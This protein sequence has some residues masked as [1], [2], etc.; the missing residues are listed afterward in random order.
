MTAF[1]FETPTIVV[2]K[3]QKVVVNCF[4]CGCTIEPR[5]LASSFVVQRRVQLFCFCCFETV[6]IFES[7]ALLT[8]FYIFKRRI[9]GEGYFSV[10]NQVILWAFVGNYKSFFEIGSFF[11]LSFSHSNVGTSKN[12]LQ[13]KAERNHAKQ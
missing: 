1:W 12:F 9:L 3:E 8:I 13:T 5:S 11:G 6:L 7:G 4:I 2:H 10:S